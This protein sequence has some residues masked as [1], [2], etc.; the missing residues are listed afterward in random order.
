MTDIKE[1]RWYTHPGFLDVA[2]KCN[3]RIDSLVKVEYWNVNEKRKF[4]INEEY[5]DVERFS[6]SPLWTDVTDKMLA[7]RSG[8][9]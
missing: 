5:L 1:G 3:R 6:L 9:V 4:Y 2:I 7:L 8:L